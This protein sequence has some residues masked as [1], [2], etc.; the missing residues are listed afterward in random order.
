MLHKKKSSNSF[1]DQVV[2]DNSDNGGMSCIGSVGGGSGG[3]C[4]FRCEG[5]L[6]RSRTGRRCVLSVRAGDS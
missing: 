1:R 5:D 3:V 6:K 2:E 4:A